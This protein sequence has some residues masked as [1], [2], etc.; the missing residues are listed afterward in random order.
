MTDPLISA[1][2]LR[3]FAPA[4]P[5]SLAPHLDAAAMMA[6]ITTPRRL[7]HWLA[8]LAQES[9]GLVRRV[10]NLNYSA[11]RLRQVWPARFPVDQK[12]TD[13]AHQP[14]RIANEVYGGRMGNVL[15]GD[16]WRYRGRGLIQLTGRDAYRA[17]GHFVA[18]D[19][20]GDPDQVL[21]DHGAAESAGGYWTWK[22]LNALADRDALEAITRTVNGGLNGLD[23]RAA[24]LSKA[25]AV[26]RG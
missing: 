4:A 17:V 13:F 11:E 23:D 9:A 21:T 15:P 5:A 8:Q 18:L 3:V 25:R 26:W 14:E 7:C 20:E 24:W 22:A 1:A 10:E 2:Q 19:L 16:G 12:A 6:G